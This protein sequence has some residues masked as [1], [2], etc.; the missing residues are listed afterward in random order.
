MQPVQLASWSLQ[1]FDAAQKLEWLFE[2]K[3]TLPGEGQGSLWALGP[4][5]EL[6]FCQLYLSTPPPEQ[7]RKAHELVGAA[8][9]GR[10][11]ALFSWSVAPERRT[12]LP[13]AA[14]HWAAQI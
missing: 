3:A 2:K 10:T 12:L 7:T 4:M 13:L 11:A 8:L 1:S 5:C 9:A 6:R 14:L